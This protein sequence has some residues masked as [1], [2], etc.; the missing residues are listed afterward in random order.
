M[1]QSIREVLLKGLR[2][3][4]LK[5]LRELLTVMKRPVDDRGED[6]EEGALITVT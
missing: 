3:L 2:E 4:L 6:E 1:L 5:G